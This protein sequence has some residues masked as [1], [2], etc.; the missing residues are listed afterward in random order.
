[1]RAVWLILGI[2]IAVALASAQAPAVTPGEVVNAAS[3][4]PAGCVPSVAP[5]SIVA[6]FGSNLAS[7][8]A[9]ADSIPLSTTL[10]NVTSVTFNGVAASLYYAGQAQINAQLPYESLAANSTGATVDIVVT[11]SAGSSV[12][13]NVSVV[14]ALPGIFTTNEGGTGQAIATDST[15][16]A[17][18][19]AAGSIP[20]VTTHPVSISQEMTTQQHALVIWCTGL[21]AVTPPI[22]DGANSYAADGTLTVRHTTLM[23]TVT[24]GGVEAQVLFSGLAPAYVGEYQVDVFLAA[25]TPTGNAVPVQISINGVTTLSNVT[26]AVAP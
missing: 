7:S 23:P 6:I 3:Y 11:N 15:D 2:T 17:I 26:I 25:D 10:S 14:P 16:G 4:C 18:A 21:G 5:G 19:A 13:Q 22:A 12:A 9:A 20:G 24:V 8:A 1:M